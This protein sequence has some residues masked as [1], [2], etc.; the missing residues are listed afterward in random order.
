MS[1]PEAV[2]RVATFLAEH[3]GHAFCRECLADRLTLD[4]TDAWN[5]AS[6]L[7]SS[8]EFEVDVGFCSFCLD[9][10]EDVAHVRWIQR[11]AADAER[12]AK[13]RIRFTSGPGS[14]QT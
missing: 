13:P 11:T 6:M 9:R 2:K 7:S 5:A 4:P 10:P 1:Q 14:P 12:P 8:P 3:P